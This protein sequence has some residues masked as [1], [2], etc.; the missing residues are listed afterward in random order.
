[1]IYVP[2][3]IN[4]S[5]QFKL[6]FLIV[7]MLT[8]I[9][10]VL[11]SIAALAKPAVDKRLSIV[12][13]VRVSANKK[14]L[15]ADSIK[16][17]LQINKIL[18]VG[19]NHTHNSVIL[20]E[21]KLKKGD[22]VSED[23]LA[24]ILNRDQQKL[25][26]LHLF[27]IV[28]IQPIPLDTGT[29]YLLVELDE[30]WYTFPVPR[31]QLSDRNFNEWWENYNHDLNRVNYGIKLY[32][33]NLWGRNHTLLLTAQFGFQKKFQLLYRVPY[34]NKK[35]K[36]GLI[37]EIDYLDGK[38][39][40][41]S[42]IDHKLHFIKSRNVLRSTQ[43]VGLT[44]TYRNNFYIQHRLK[45]EYRHTTI[46]DTLQKLNPNYLGEEKKRQQFDALTYEFISDHRDVSAYPLKGYEFQVGAT[47]SGIGLRQD[48]NKTSAQIRFSG[49]IDLK[50]NFFLSNLSFL[51]WSTPTN[52]PYFNYGSMGYDKIF[53]RGY[54][55][56]V[57]EGPKFALNKTT[58][59]K[60]IFSRNWRLNNW[61]IKQFNYFPISIYLKTYADF[62]YVSNYPVY[63]Q[64]EKNSFLSDKILS[65]GGFG[66]D[67]VTA[68]DMA[69]RFEYSF[70]SQNNGFFLHFKKEF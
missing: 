10:T 19:N 41:E 7:R 56:Y 16:Q 38:S 12:D 18:I 3:L 20:R 5:V 6:P 8:L 54:E 66:L 49:F 55:V 57:I 17:Y 34:I 67:I 61:P 24:S 52:L 1:M 62:G 13:T 45:Y 59:K 23:D 42:T 35:Q 4:R 65:G 15:P 30:R 22:V 44:Y 51:Y 58:F 32:Q 28:T 11:L 2:F 47:Q 37:F 27:N 70:T 39:V 21:L 14:Q 63:E 50:K 29:I 33:Y 64:T 60:K 25:F 26:N 40:P 31:F 68:Y 9:C 43:G 36:E 69:I 48:L 46:A 53:I